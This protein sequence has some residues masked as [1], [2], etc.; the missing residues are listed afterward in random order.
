MINSETKTLFQNIVTNKMFEMDRILEG[1]QQASFRK[2]ASQGLTQSGNEMHLVTQNATNSLKTRAQFILRQLLHCL[3]VGHVQLDT[4]TVTEALWLLQDAIQTQAN[5]VGARLFQ[6]PVFS[7][8]G[9]EQAKRQL[10]AQYAQEGPR[11]IDRLST[12]LK[13]AAAASQGSHPELFK[14]RLGAWGASVD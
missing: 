14:L 9:F 1:V 5:N 3:A 4:E 7:S 13:L 8:T 12:K 10:Q 11:L 6:Y 2:M